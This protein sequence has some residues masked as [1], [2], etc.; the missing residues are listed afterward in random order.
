MHPKVAVILLN[1]NS[2]DHSSNCIQSLQ[3]CDYPNFEIILVDNGSMDGSGN[4]LKAKF[5]EII[6]IASPT[7]EG[8]AAGNNRGFSYAIENQFTYAM[9]LNNDVF[10]EPDFI[11]KLIQYMETHPD[12][13][14]IQ[15][16]IFFNHDR[17]KI[18]NGGSY[19]LSWLGWTYSKRYMRKAG[20]LQSQ[21]QQVDWITGCAFL[22]K[23]SILKEVGL[24]KEAFFIYYEDVDLSFRI[25]SKGYEL[26][27]HPDSI[28]YHIAGSSNKAKVKGKEGFSSP[29]VHYL[30]SRN[31]IWFL[32]M[33]TKWYQWPS[34]L[35]ILFLYYLSIMFYFAF[36][37]RINKLKSLLRGI[38][39]GMKGLKN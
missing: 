2:F 31:H 29:F 30:N 16:K 27:Y 24:L 23:T 35:V 32:K 39:D 26:I 8:F 10:V 21:F 4:L 19:F 12:T 6:L 15:P 3:L 20:V 14:A 22:T 34:T 1:W 17:K 18:W 28:I 13:G 37:W 38:L 9:M 11:S 7:N 36:R 25:R 33:W 5:P